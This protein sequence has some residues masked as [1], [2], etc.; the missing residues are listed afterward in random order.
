LLYVRI[1]RERLAVVGI[2]DT[3]AIVRGGVGFGGDGAEVATG[4]VDQ[5]EVFDSCLEEKKVTQTDLDSQAPANDAASTL[6]VCS[7]EDGE[8]WLWQKSLHL[9]C[10]LS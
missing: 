10:C 1:P 7:M 9:F 6:R 4:E 8:Y 2:S 5:V 3:N